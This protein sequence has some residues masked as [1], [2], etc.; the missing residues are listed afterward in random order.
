MM[1]PSGCGGLP[2]RSLPHRGAE[3]SRIPLSI[4]ADDEDFAIAIQIPM[5][6]AQANTGRHGRRQLLPRRRRHEEK[7]RQ[8]TLQ[9]VAHLAFVVEAVHPAA[10]VE[11]EAR[12]EIVVATDANVS[13]RLPV[14]PASA[15]RGRGALCASSAGS[16]KRNRPLTKK[17]ADAPSVP[18][19]AAR[20]LRRNHHPAAAAPKTGRRPMSATSSRPGKRWRSRGTTMSPLAIRSPRMVPPP[21]SAQPP[22]LARH[23][24]RRRQFAAPPAIEATARQQSQRRIQRQ[25]V[26]GQL[27]LTDREEHEIDGD[28]AQEE[29]RGRSGVISGV[30]RQ[31]AAG[32]PQGDA[33]EHRP[34][35]EAEEHAEHVIEERS[36]VALHRRHAA[37]EVM[38]DEEAAQEDALRLAADQHEPRHRHE[39]PQQHAEQ[40][41]RPE[42]TAQ[43][44]ASIAGT[45][46]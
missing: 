27:R 11:D 31:F 2:F 6:A 5:P 7:D 20:A 25:D 37:F 22:M 16:P 23:P 24:A 33:E 21:T 36:A 26:I 3:A 1:K 18:S 8:G 41:R 13:I 35:Q 9:E 46:R 17:M 4:V 40:Q 39:H 43:P 10:T 19:M 28:P 45:D 34:G 44:G 29:A 38:V 42:A 15:T 32:I 14:P 12:L 30:A